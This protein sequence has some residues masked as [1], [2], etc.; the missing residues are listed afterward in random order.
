MLTIWQLGHYR[1]TA[2]LTTLPEN[3]SESFCSNTKLYIIFIYSHA[4]CLKSTKLNA[5]NSRYVLKQ[6]MHTIFQLYT[7]LYFK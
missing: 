5:T 3:M 7:L 4:D 1:V 2:M 6:H